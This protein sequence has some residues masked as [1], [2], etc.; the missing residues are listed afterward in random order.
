MSEQNGMGI[1]SAHFPGYLS[2]L[3]SAV[4]AANESST[5]FIN[6]DWY[7]DHRNDDRGALAIYALGAPL[8]LNYGS[9]YYPEQRAGFMKS[10]PVQESRFPE[11][12]DANQPFLMS[13]EATWNSSNHQAYMSFKNSGYSKAKFN[14]DTYWTRHV[15]QFTPKVQTPIFII[16]DTFSNVNLDHIW[17]FN[18]TSKDIVQTPSGPVDPPSR[19]W[20]YQGNPKENPTPSSNI[21]LAAG[22]FHRFDF[23]GVNWIAHPA[24]GINW[25]VYLAPTQA[26]IANLAEWGHN[27]IPTAE[28]DEYETTNNNASFEERQIMMR[29]KGKESFYT[30]IVPY[31]KGQRPAGLTVTKSGASTTV[32]TN[33]FTF[34][35]DLNKYTYTETGRNILSTYTTQ[36]LTFA[37][38]TISGN[39][40]ELEV[41]TDTIFA[42][43]HG[44]AGNRQV[45]LPSGSWVLNPTSSNAT[46]NNGIWTLNYTYT[47][48]LNNSYLGGYAEFRWLRGVECTNLT[49]PVNGATN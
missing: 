6:G 42:R 3:R 17:S 49:S 23:T 18:F 37:G 21:S 20:N 9:L 8:S 11:W 41:K 48:S 25:E 35:T 30:V 16:K 2:N 22:G 47:D 4:G 40:M 36:S 43:V 27:F 29:V 5:W 12:D 31:D 15:F 13:D 19:F 14:G 10:I 39:P 45:T 44:A 28:G 34:V 24:G 1:G 32:Q 33:D 26:Q 7:T 38:A 46:F